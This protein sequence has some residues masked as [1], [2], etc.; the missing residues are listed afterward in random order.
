MILPVMRARRPLMSLTAA[1]LVLGACKFPPPEDVPDDGAVDAS[2]ACTPSTTTCNEDVLTVCDAEGHATNTAC[3]FGCAPSGDRCGDL[4][5]SNGLAMYLDRA[6]TAAPVVLAGEA[7]VDTDTG[8]VTVGGNPFAVQGAIASSA[9]VEIFVIIAKSFEANNVTVRGRRA[10]AIV[11]D[12]DVVLHGTLSVS[13]SHEVPGAGAG[14]ANDPAYTA[15]TGSAG[16]AGV[17]GAGGGGFGT[18]GGRGGNGGPNAGGEPGAIAGNASL[19]PLRGGCPGAS[20]NAIVNPEPLAEQP[21][22]GGGAIQISTRSTVHIGTAAF[23][24]A[25]GGGAKGIT[26]DFS[27]FELIG[28]P[29]YCGAGSG[30]GAGGAILIEAARLTIENGGGVT[31]NGGGGHCGAYGVAPDGRVARS[32]AAGTDCSAMSGAGSG[33]AG[34]A[35]ETAAFSGGDGQTTGGGGGGGAGRIRINLPTGVP[36]DPSSA[37]VSPQPSLGTLLAR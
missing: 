7:T 16:Q 34:A 21:G 33:G 29:P 10:L 28:D 9:P 1:L 36:F 37:I 8:R 27:C 20:R 18:A 25:S 23:I 32:T 17:G 5:P 30:G 3:T 31:A 13:A 24:T 26:G 2:D 15:H 11:S 19:T 4:A 35:G 6:R 14:V 22:A 12:G